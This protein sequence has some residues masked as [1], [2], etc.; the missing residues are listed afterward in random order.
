MTKKG[1]IENKMA[2]NNLYELT[3]PQK[4]IWYTE[5]FYKGS[6]IHNICG[7]AIINEVVNFNLLKEALLIFAQKNDVF[8]YKLKMQDN[9]VKQYI[10]NEVNTN[11]PFYEVK[12]YNELSH[13]RE[14]IVSKPFQLINSF[15]YNFYIF[16]MPNNHGAFVVNVHH[17][18]SDA[19]SLGFLSREVIR[20]YGK[21][22][23]NEYDYNEEPIYSYT[24]YINSEE[25]YKNS[26]RFKKD[27]QY[28]ETEFQTIPE[29]AEIPSTKNNINKEISCVGERLSYNINEA[30]LNDIKNYCKENSIT[31]YNF[32]MSI[33]SI[34]ISEVSNLDKIVVGTPILNRTR[35]I[36]G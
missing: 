15:L 4:N 33:Y 22:K 10:S 13:I 28:W 23:N 26:E 20:I 19:W 36:M 21:L 18:I 1:E 7:T 8:R 12:S 3:N 9:N 6:N 30:L 27:K 11:I 5:Q 24:E 25:K 17:L 14:K 2:D 16:K 31:L 35:Q 32:F 29:I 34:Y